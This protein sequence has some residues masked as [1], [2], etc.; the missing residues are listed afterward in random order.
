MTIMQEYFEA[1]I[2]KTQTQTQPWPLCQRSRGD[3]YLD[4]YTQ[5]RW[6]GWKAAWQELGEMNQ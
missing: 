1:Y 3:S 5:L 4:L 2:H 6:E